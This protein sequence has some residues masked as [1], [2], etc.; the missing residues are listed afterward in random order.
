M[1]KM[2]SKYKISFI[3]FLCMIALLSVGFSSWTL[4]GES[5]NQINSNIEA[6]IVINSNEYVFLNTGYGSG[7]GINCFKYSKSGYLDNDSRLSNYG[8]VDVYY[9]VDLDKCR[10]V[11]ANDTS[12]KIDITLKAQNCS[13]EFKPFQ[14]ISSRKSTS[15]KALNM[16]DGLEDKDYISVSNATISSDKNN[17]TI[18]IVL[19]N[20]LNAE[21]ESYHELNFLVQYTFFATLD[22]A[23]YP[24]YDNFYQYYANN[25]STTDDDLKFVS[26]VIVCGTNSTN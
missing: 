4:S 17:Y 16:V 12:I 11:F 13:S 7:T 14:I 21:F 19:K 9:T 2:F 22:N 6:D 18:S 3:I 1:Q 8:Y 5:T 25:E 23:S 15:H 24:F 26:S 10:S 20:V